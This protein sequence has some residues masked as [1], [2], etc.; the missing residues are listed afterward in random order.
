MP[1]D[2]K[3]MLDIIGGISQVLANSKDT[4]TG[5]DPFDQHPKKEKAGLNREEGN[6]LKDSRQLFDGFSCKIHG[7][8]L[9]V[10]YQ[11]D[12]L[13]RNV[14]QNGFERDVEKK[15]A[16]I[17]S[18]IKKEYKKVTKN[19]LSLTGEKDCHIIVQK[20][21]NIRTFITATKSFKI[22]GINL[23]AEDPDSKNRLEANIKKFLQLGKKN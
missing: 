22:G 11:T 2:N 13:M 4:Y 15:L 7:D 14:H 12:V 1:K 6:P 16:E 20:T 19:T 18:F 23:P 17:A 10:T 5:Y 9:M 3:T 21:S 8:Q